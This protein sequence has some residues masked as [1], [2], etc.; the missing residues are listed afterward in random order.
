MKLRPF[1]KVSDTPGDSVQMTGELTRD[2]GPLSCAGGTNRDARPAARP[3]TKFFD[4]VATDD[5]PVESNGGGDV[6]RGREAAN[7]V[8]R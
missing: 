3:T 1:R 6:R 5:R 7:D 8:R 4:N 2:L